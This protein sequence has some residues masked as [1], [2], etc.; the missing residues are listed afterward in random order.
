MNAITK[1][2]RADNS[3]KTRFHTSNG[4]LC[5]YPSEFMR[6]LATTVVRISMKKYSSSPWLVYS[7]TAHIVPFVSGKRIFEFGSGMSTLWFAERSLEVVS[8]ESNSEWYFSVVGHAH[9]Q[10]CK[11]VRVIYADSKASYLAAIAQAG[12]KFDLILIDGLYRKDCV[13]LARAYLN[14]NGIAIVD[15][16]DADNGLSE[17]VKNLFEDSTILSFQGWGPGT[18]HASETTIVQGIPI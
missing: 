10:R 9:A 12:G 5:L 3:R 17:T 13:A 6:A 2:I 1:L 14:P 8:V 18:L 4:H 7:A 11:N 16:T 15:N